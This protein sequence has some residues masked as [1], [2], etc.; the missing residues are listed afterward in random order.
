[1]KIFRLWKNS[2]YEK[3][4]LTYSSRL[5]DFVYMLEPGDVLWIPSGYWHE[6]ETTTGRAILKKAF[7]SR[8]IMCLP[9]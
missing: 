1:V 7:S 2:P 5:P 3:D 6:V 8:M 9:T 4:G